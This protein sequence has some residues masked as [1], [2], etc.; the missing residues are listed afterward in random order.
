MEHPY[1][2]RSRNKETNGKSVT[3]V[4]DVTNEKEVKEAKKITQKAIRNWR[5]LLGKKTTF[6]VI[7]N[8][9]NEKERTAQKL[10]TNFRAVDTV[11]FIT[12]KKDINLQNNH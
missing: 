4:I 11:A 2:L 9:Y 7:I 8:P 5:K 10:H 1:I 6:T 12:Y 3:V